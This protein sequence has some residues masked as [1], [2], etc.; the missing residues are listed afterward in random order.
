MRKSSAAHAP[1]SAVTTGAV[2]GNDHFSGE[3]VPALVLGGVVYLGYHLAGGGLLG[4]AAGIAA[5]VVLVGGLYVGGSLWCQYKQG[6][7]GGC[8]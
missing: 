7:A 8:T 2:G 3:I 5:P 1:R 4:I 6:H